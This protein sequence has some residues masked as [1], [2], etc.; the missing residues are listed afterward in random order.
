MEN[1]N[2]SSLTIDASMLA[3]LSDLGY[4]QMTPIQA[5]SL[6][7]ILNRRDVIAQAKTGSGKTAAFGIGLL[8]RLDMSS[9]HVQAIVLCPTRELSDQVAKELRRLSRATPNV[10]ILT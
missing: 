7:H 6:E 8:S 3:T 9:C 2:F 10:R 1:L 5:S 4:H